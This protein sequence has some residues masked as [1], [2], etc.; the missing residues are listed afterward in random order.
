MNN[1]SKA[2]VEYKKF[3]MQKAQSNQ[4]FLTWSLYF[5]LILFVTIFLLMFCF[6]LLLGCA[7]HFIRA[8]HY[9]HAFHIRLFLFVLLKKMEIGMRKDVFC[10]IYI[11]FIVEV[12]HILFH[13]MLVYLV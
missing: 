3:W 5:I 13:N 10:I 9:I 8:L 4:V 1:N 11:G 2:R 7:L 12:G 6:F